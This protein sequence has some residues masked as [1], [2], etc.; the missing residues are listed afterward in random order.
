MSRLRRWCVL[1]VAVLALAVCAVAVRQA[2][3]LRNEATGNRAVVERE[4]TEEVVGAVSSAVERLWSYDYRRLERLDQ[5]L[6]EVGTAPF[7]REY[8]PAYREVR[9][10]APQR[11]AVVTATVAEAAVSTLTRTRAVLLVFVNQRTGGGGAAGARL[12]VEAVLRD[13]EWRIAGIT[14]L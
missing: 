10:L 11:R 4:P 14:P 6:P 3:S 9:R 7:R 5:V 8:A 13:G 1:V 2:V 12:R